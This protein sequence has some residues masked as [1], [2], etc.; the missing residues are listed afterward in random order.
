MSV[1]I[2]M[3]MLLSIIVYVLVEP[4][5]TMIVHLVLAFPECWDMSVPTRSHQRL[6]PCGL[7]HPISTSSLHPANAFH[8]GPR[9][10]SSSGASGRRSRPYRLLRTRATAYWYVS[11]LRA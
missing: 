8:L 10:I 7:Q 5:A 9:C 2:V 3:D 11:P 4:C 1:M 6:G